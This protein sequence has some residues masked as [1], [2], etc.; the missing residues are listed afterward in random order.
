MID[1]GGYQ[2]LLS[3]KPRPLTPP[4]S[5]FAFCKTPGTGTCLILGFKCESRSNHLGSISRFARA[6]RE[7]LDAQQAASLI[8]PHDLTAVSRNLP[9][10]STVKLTNP[11]MAAR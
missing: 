4:G 5:D 2:R 9:I 11:E 1:A 6:T 10:G 8:I 7:E 3:K